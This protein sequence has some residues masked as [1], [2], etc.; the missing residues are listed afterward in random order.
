[1]STI[2]QIFHHE[3]VNDETLNKSLNEIVSGNI[4]LSMASIKAGNTS[5]IN[6]AYFGYTSK[7]AL[8]FLSPP[9]AQHSQNILL[10]GAVAVSIFDSHQ[11]S[12]SQ[13]RGIQLF[14]VCRR[15][16]GLEIAEG[17]DV[18]SERFPSISGVIKSPEDF[19]KGI[20]KSK[21]YIIL[22][23]EIKIFDEQI[24]GEEKWVTVIL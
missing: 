3:S 16:V 23:K 22:P 11:L 9:T 5:W 19:D 20:I 17:L 24:F 7:L 18:Y 10:N 12:A 15:A 14:G 2:Q 8:Y 13:K 21:L 6:T 4:L 1:M